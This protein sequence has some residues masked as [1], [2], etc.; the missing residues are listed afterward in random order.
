M[1]RYFAYLS[2]EP[3]E[4]D[5]AL[6]LNDAPARD[7]WNEGNGDHTRRS[8]IFDFWNT[9]PKENQGWFEVLALVPYDHI[10]A[11][12]ELGDNYHQEPHLY[13]EFKGD[14][15]PFYGY[16]KN[17]SSGGQWDKFEFS[18]ESLSD[19]RIAKFPTELRSVVDAAPYS[20]KRLFGL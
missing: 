9:L 14:T 18:P 3:I 1:G 19:R 12:D 16:G 17:V 4:W 15:G 7:S 6:S 20:P 5:A 10:I 2:R 13:V 11:I 8:F